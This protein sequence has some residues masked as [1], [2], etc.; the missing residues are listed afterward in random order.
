LPR[1][2]AF[3]VLT[4]SLVPGSLTAAL[5]ALFNAWERNDVPALVTVGTTLARV[6]LGTAALQLGAGIVGLALVSLLL[7]LVLVVVF[8][9]AMRRILRVKLTAPVP[10][11]LLPMAA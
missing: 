2:V 7:N 3:A 1:I 4:L 8:L 9:V 10:T 6:A 11:E 5:S